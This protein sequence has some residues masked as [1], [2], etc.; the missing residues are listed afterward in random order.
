MSLSTQFETSNLQPAFHILAK[1]TG[2][3]CNLDCKYCYFL[4]KEML[5]PDSNFRMADEMLETYIR[6]TIQAHQGPEIV[7]AWQ[8]GEPTLMGLDFFRR[9]MAYEKKYLKPGTNVQNTLQTNGTLLDDEWCEF[10]RENGF[11]IDTSVDGVRSGLERF[12]ALDEAERHAMGQRARLAASAC[13]QE[14]FVDA[15]RAFYRS[16]TPQGN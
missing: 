13:S 3:I 11:L 14:H 1:P 6:Q 8:G 15:W 4:S 16:L 5:Y 7:I 12:L 10:F 9:S 2:S